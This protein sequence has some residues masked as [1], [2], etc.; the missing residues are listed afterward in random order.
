M[1]GEKDQRNEVGACRGSIARGSLRAQTT[2]TS[3]QRREA[4]ARLEMGRGVSGLSQGIGKQHPGETCLQN[5]GSPGLLRHRRL[6][7]AVLEAAQSPRRASYVECVQPQLSFAE[8][9]TYT[10]TQKLINGLWKRECST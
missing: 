8:K 10:C 4:A 9:S 3:N 2:A 6:L 1:Q 5:P 7:M